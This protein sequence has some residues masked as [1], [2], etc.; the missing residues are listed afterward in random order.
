MKVPL[1]EAAWAIARPR[2]NGLSTKFWKIAS[3]RGKKFYRNS[4]GS[5]TSTPHGN[6][7]VRPIVQTISPWI[8][9]VEC[10]HCPIS[11]YTTSG[12]HRTSRNQNREVGPVLNRRGSPECRSLQNRRAC[13]PVLAYRSTNAD[14]S[15]DCPGLRKNEGRDDCP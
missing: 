2:N 10:R 5:S 1:Y 15:C 3:R 7:S 8:I 9:E 4:N 13:P 11:P 14:W 12:F 6:Y